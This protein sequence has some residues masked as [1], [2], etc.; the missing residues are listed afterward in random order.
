MIKLKE[1]REKRGFTQQDLA[2][3][4]G[5]SRITISAIETGVQKNVTVKTLISISKALN[6]KIMDFF[7]RIVKCTLQKG[8]L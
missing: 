1:L 6:V 2:E 3:K 5:V 7:K 8:G 4:S